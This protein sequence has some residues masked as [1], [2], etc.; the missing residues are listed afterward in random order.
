MSAGSPPADLDSL[1]LVLREAA[2]AAA[3]GAGG[4]HRPVPALKL[5]LL[6]INEVTAPCQKD[7][8]SHLL[9]F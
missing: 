1:V 2:A 8:S 5:H 6:T 7:C 9:F 3:T 4:F